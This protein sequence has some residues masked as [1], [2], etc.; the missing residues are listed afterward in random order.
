MVKIEFTASLPDSGAWFAPKKDG[1]GVLRIELSASEFP[2]VIQMC[3]FMDCFT[4]GGASF[5][6]TINSELKE[7]PK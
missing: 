3:R 6:V 2:R 7:F 4:N 1:S 5:R